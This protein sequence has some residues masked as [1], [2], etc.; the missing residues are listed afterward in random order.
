MPV[1]DPSLDD[2]HSESSFDS[3]DED[4]L[5]A[6][7]EWEES[8]Q[9]LR[10][11]VGGLLLPYF[12]KFLGRRWSYWAIKHPTQMQ[13]QLIPAILKG[14]DVLLKDAAGSGKS[15]GMLL[16]LLNKPRLDSSYLPS[17]N[18]TSPI[19][20]SLL[21]VPHRD[22][23]FQ[24][25]HWVEQLTMSPG[26]SS[27]HL[28]DSA[29][30][31][32]VRDKRV[33]LSERIEKLRQ[34]PPHILIGTP[35]AVLDVLEADVS[36]LQLSTL[37]CVVVDEVD[38][39]IESVP[40]KSREK[41]F[42]K[43]YLKAKKKIERH[44]SPTRR[45]LD[46]IY[47]SRLQPREKDVENRGDTLPQ[48][49]M[50]S[51]TLRKH[52][53]LFLF[54][55][56][57]WL[58]RDQLLKFK[59][60]EKS[61]V[62]H[63]TPLITDNASVDSGILHSLLIVSPNG[64]TKNTPEAQESPI[65][66]LE[67]GEF[68]TP[69]SIFNNSTS[70]AV[71][72]PTE[73]DGINASSPPLDPNIL[74]AVATAFALDVPSIAL[75]V[76]PAS[77]P[78]QRTVQ[79]L[80]RLGVNAQA[81]DLTAVNQGRQHLLTGGDAV[82]E[83]PTLLIST[84]ANTRGLDLPHLTHV[85]IL[86]IPGGPRVNGQTFD[87]YV[88]L[89]GRV[90]RFGRGGKVIT[91]VEGNEA[92]GLDEA[93]KMLRVFKEVGVTPTTEPSSSATS[94]SQSLSL[95]LTTSSATITSTTRSGGQNVPVTTIV[96]TI[97]NVTFTI[98]PTATTSAATNTSSPSPTP[99]PIVL[100]TKLDPAFGV[101]GAVLILTGLPSAFWG[102]KNRWTSF[103]LI[104]FYT[105]SLVCFVLILKFGILPA[106]NPPSQ[107]LRG[108]FVLACAIA[109]IAGGGVAIFF[110]KAAKY[111]IGAWGGFAFALWIQ[112]FRDGGII[113]P[114]GFRWIMYIGCGVVGFILC[115]IPK[116]HYHI[117]LV[118]TAF[119]GSSAFILGVDCFT[120]AGL[121][122]FYI[123]NIGFQALFTKYTTN[124]IQFPVSQ[125]MQI[126]LGLI[127][128]VSLMG[129]AVQL[130]ILRV[131]QRK[132]EEIA[133]E[134]RKRDEEQELQAAERFQG[135]TSEK[136]DWE[137]EHP[138]LPKHFRNESGYSSTPLMK[139]LDSPATPNSGHHASSFT[140]TDS[141]PRAHSN[142]SE[143]FAG[144]A[145]DEDVRRAFRSQ[146]PGALPALDLG[147]G[148]KD[149][150]PSNFIA[151]NTQKDSDTDGET[152]KKKQ[153][154]MA[155]IMELRRSIDVLKSETPTPSSAS[156][157][158]H[159]SLL[160]RRAS[161]DASAALAPGPSHLRPPRETDPRGR[162]H[163]MELSHLAR[164]SL[165]G[166]SIS[167][168]T[169]APLRDNDWDAYLHDRKLVQPPTGITP[170][171][172][173]T[174]SGSSAARLPVPQAVVEALDRR[175]RRENALGVGSGSDSD[176]T[177]LA[178]ITPARHNSGGNVPVSILPPKKL[179]VHSPSPQRADNR[180]RTFEELNERH[181]EKMRD[182]QGPLTKAERE[183]AELA[184]AKQRW[185]KSKAV[186]R[187]A[188]TK[189]QA[190]KAAVLEQRKRD[191]LK[192]SSTAHEVR[193]RRHSRSMSGDRLATTGGPSA[194]RMST[195]KVEDWQRYQEEGEFGARPE[196]GSGV[197]PGVPFPGGSK[198][199]SSHDQR[200]AH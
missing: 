24:F 90:G 50:T 77:S 67:D 132:L 113:H 29:A 137:R 74:E 89:A 174:Q 109:G 97:F 194:K 185:E 102:H 176:D 2:F 35:Q 36:A 56:G 43:A 85:F 4:Y 184:A 114:I 8:L 173:T 15:F 197:E 129:I 79:E 153:D 150:V 59:Q 112:C 189:R 166:E 55:E 99:E 181:R 187:D 190:E 17:S 21:I 20:S 145:P 171:I 142:V 69:E 82:K 76:L 182:L 7:Q 92:A 96:P 168:P 1:S 199:Q 135:L 191:D 122:E 130:R 138:P 172:A 124:G 45:L 128:A 12:G 33:S 60:S 157:S 65:A 104:G 110:W 115:T 16:A 93:G 48:L 164:S 42:H 73:L 126:E 179:A 52:L 116:I 139:D 170:P 120:T 188:V 177:P 19:I 107:S 105:L 46:T 178:R 34:N 151:Q 200:R 72:I 53:D 25:M 193:P 152:A 156:A 86:G 6:Q 47:A 98:T 3:E 155:E 51:A 101:L 119:V 195:L 31:V 63:S 18:P 14:A 169:S 13:Q 37:S 175:K 159:Q 44:P 163:S 10:Q 123:W 111:F 149:D 5:L 134:E 11:L 131:L 147:L 78:V 106:V 198:R 141:R 91:V 22:L 71:D 39:L 94:T 54:R 186:E 158:R 143:F 84:L 27:P 117:L 61:N 64:D 62:N 28:G 26:V 66:E 58:R 75:L 133:E 81:L 160:S 148:I 196:R 165:L 80:Q 57:R 100:D 146:S 87:A 30:Q 125:T 162:V 83:S 144:P 40:I 154:L 118:S 95:S 68:I 167:R 38:Y 121:K 108:Y 41:T 49:V 140:L 161:L 180:S 23:A 183:Q 103:F 127:G 136:D 32:I 192:R 9:Q 70:S 88:H